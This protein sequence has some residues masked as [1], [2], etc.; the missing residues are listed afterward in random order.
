MAW[1]IPTVLGVIGGILL[2]LGVWWGSVALLGGALLAL[3]DARPLLAVL[4]LVGGAAGFGSARLVSV[5]TDALRPWLGAQVTLEGEWDGQFLTLREPR[6]RVVL[7]PKPAARPGHL[8]VSGRLVAPDGRRTP[9]G[10]DQAAWLRAQG[11]VF[12]PTPTAVLVA[13]RVRSSEREGGARGWFRQGLTAGLGGGGGA[14]MQA[15]EL[16]DRNDIGREDFAEG[17]AV[18]DAF[19]RA[20]LAHLMA[21][22]G[23]NVALITGVLV[24]LLGFARLGPGWRYGVP[25]FLLIFY[26]L[27][28]GL[29]PSITRAVIMGFVVLVALA[30]GRGKVDPYGLT[31]LAALVCLL[32]FPLWLLDIGFR[33]SFLAVLGLTLAGRAADR[34]PAALPYWLRLAV[35]ATVLAEL[36]TLPV[37]AGT[38]GQLPLV[39]LPANL[40]AAPVMAVLV[41]T[42]F[43]AGLLGPAAAPLNLLNRA[44]ADALLGI[45]WAAGQFPVLPWGTVSPAGVIAYA[46]CAGA[47]VLWLVGR[48][49][50]PA[51][52]G[53]VLACAVL[54]TLPGRL[55]PPRDLI[56]LDVGQGDSTLLRVPGLTMLV[57]AGG[58]VNSDYDVG[59]R[60]VVPAL[61]ALGVRKLDI[62]VAT[63]ADTDHI[64]GLA[65]VLRSLPV[66]ELWIGHRKAGDPVLDAVLAAAQ[67][68]R[69]PVR[70][71]TR[72]DRI[73]AAGLSVTV[74]WPPGNVWSTADNDNSVAVK[75][76]SGAWSTALLGDLADPAE[77]M[78]GVGR[79]NLLKA[80]HHGSR[81]STGAAL[82]AQA[83]PQHAVISVGRN[84]YGH[85]NADVLGRLQAA[86]TKVWRTDEVGTITWPVP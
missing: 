63:H 51:V 23:Q 79:V 21:L 7:A 85:P 72:G 50:A 14:L 6:A 78:I 5:R 13:A 62:V 55:H 67:A 26:L 36:A 46:V 81:F 57:D 31:A 59:S 73:S 52:L 48:V 77:S 40:L 74:L 49:R 20:G 66:G 8:R 27:L 25:A 44:L 9:G 2:S 34:L 28:V 54:T 11:G 39:G 16:G 35:A 86:G 4:A 15:I 29:S 70:Q 68:R 32:L 83:T 42:G 30:V 69:V 24:W 37:I 38:F 82:L 75:V 43:V 22:S 45:A 61:R 84:T 64:E 1:P 76:E 71:V 41:P 12:L 33:L 18:R 53:T 58:S 3:V 19:A 56:F 80:A 65:S 60:T 47:G 17:Y 10:F